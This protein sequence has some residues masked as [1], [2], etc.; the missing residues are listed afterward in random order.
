MKQKYGILKPVILLVLL[1]LC[2]TGCGEEGLEYGFDVR[3]LNDSRYAAYKSEKNTF[4][5]NDVTLDFYYGSLTYSSFETVKK[6]I[7]YPNFDIYFNPEGGEKVLI[8]QV[9][10]EFFSEKYR[11]TVDDARAKYNHKEAFTIPKELF[12]GE[13]GVIYFQ[14]YGDNIRTEEEDYEVI[15]SINICYKVDGDKVILSGT[16]FE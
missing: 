12:T 10:E 3:G 15:F 8:K 5:I 2:L 9:N 16:G 14:G 7:S 11:V 6:T 13:T 4:D 1:A